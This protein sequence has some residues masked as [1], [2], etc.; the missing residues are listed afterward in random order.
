MSARRPFEGFTSRCSRVSSWVLCEKKMKW[1]LP[2]LGTMTG[3][4]ERAIWNLSK[5]FLNNRCGL[6]LRTTLRCTRACGW[7]GK[8]T[9]RLL[10]N[11]GI[12]RTCTIFP[13]VG[14]A[15]WILKALQP[16]LLESKASFARVHPVTAPF[17]FPFSS[18]GP[19]S[20][21]VTWSTERQEVLTWKTELELP[22]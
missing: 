21:P 17:F 16:Q 18:S 3:G 5:T 9:G 20:N 15:H 1:W 14:Y 19:Q 7:N 10:Q 22:L 12:S 8:L 2:S 13:L 6:R 11:S 4:E